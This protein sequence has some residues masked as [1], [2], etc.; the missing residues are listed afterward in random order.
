M[1]NLINFKLIYVLYNIN[2]N[3]PSKTCSITI[4]RYTEMKIILCNMVFVNKISLCTVCIEF[5][6]YKHLA[7]S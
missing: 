2:T 6:L 1:E 3:S 5:I 4:I 7:I